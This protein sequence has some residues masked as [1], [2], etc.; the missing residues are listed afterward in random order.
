MGQKEKFTKKTLEYFNRDK[1]LVVLGVTFMTTLDKKTFF[2]K[3]I[4]LYCQVKNNEVLDRLE[5]VPL[6]IEIMAN[7]YT[8]WVNH[9]GNFMDDFYLIEPE[10]V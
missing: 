9:Q 7:C 5:K 6:G 2:P 1:K 4:S 10:K 3:H 8:D